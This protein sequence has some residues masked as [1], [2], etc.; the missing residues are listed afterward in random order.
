[1]N[2]RWWWF[3]VATLYLWSQVI[4]GAVDFVNERPVE[5]LAVVCAATLAF[6][7]LPV[8]VS[9]RRHAQRKRGRAAMY[10][11][12]PRLGDAGAEPGTT[13]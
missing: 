1:V 2:E 3:F 12:V 8:F 10:E 5:R 6:V 13:K 7:M 4:G 11:W 9:L